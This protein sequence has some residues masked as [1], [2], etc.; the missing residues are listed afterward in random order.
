MH[1]LIAAHDGGDHLQRDLDLVMVQGQESHVLRIWLQS[2]SDKLLWPAAMLQGHLHEQ[3]GLRTR[4][5][6]V[7][8]DTFQLE[9]SHDDLGFPNLSFKQLT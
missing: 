5:L 1:A 7:Q 3:L 9:R 8:H 6:F 2:D 4:L